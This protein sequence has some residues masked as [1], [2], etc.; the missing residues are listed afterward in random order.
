M[1]LLQ[2]DEEQYAAFKTRSAGNFLQLYMPH[3]PA[4]IDELKETRIFWAWWCNQWLL[5]DEALL[6]HTCFVMC[7]INDRINQ[8]KLLHSPE[9]LISK[10]VV[11]SVIF[12]NTSISK[13]PQP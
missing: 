4:L 8:Y 9:N 2:W 1:P 5:R 6:L 13:K 10:M 12:T 11:D 3:Y 7:S